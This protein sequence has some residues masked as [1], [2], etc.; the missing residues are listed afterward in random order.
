MAVDKPHLYDPGIYFLT[1]TNYKWLPLFHSTNSF[2][3]VYIRRGRVSRSPAK[4]AGEDSGAT[5]AG[6]FLCRGRVSRSD[7][8]RAGEDSGATRAGDFKQF[9]IFN[10]WP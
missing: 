7:A 10:S 5:R 6:D 2:D 3:L 8:K 9:R 1:F 4:R